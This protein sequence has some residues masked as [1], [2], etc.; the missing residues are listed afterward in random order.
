MRLSG[1]DAGTRAC[2]KV[3]V[4]RFSSASVMSQGASR[5]QGLRCR[6]AADK[7]LDARKFRGIRS[8]KWLV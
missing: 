3:M 2:P 7:W 5:T 4:T 6:S 8:E 1:V